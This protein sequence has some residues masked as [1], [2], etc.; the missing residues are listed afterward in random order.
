MAHARLSPSGSSRWMSCPGS[1]HLEALLPPD[2]RQSPYAARGTAIHELSEKALTISKPPSNWLGKQ[3][4]GFEVDQ[5]MV[6]IANVYVDWINEAKGLKFFEQRVSLVHVIPDCFGT[7]DCIILNQGRLI[8]ADLKTGAGVPVS[9][10]GNTQL[11]IYALGAFEKY[12]WLYGFEEITLVIIQP[13]I[14]HEPSVWT[15]TREELLEFAE[16]VKKAYRDIV[17]K[18]EHYVASD[19]ACR[20]CRAKTVC[21]ELNKVAKE[22]AQADFRAMREEMDAEQLADNLKRVPLLKAFIEA[23]E[24]SAKDRLLEGKSVPGFKVVE[25]RR[26][27]A[28][29]DESAVE[30]ALKEAGYGDVVYS[31]PKLLTVAQVEKVLKGT[32]FELD[33]FVETKPGSPT[34]ATEDDKRRALGPGSRAASDFAGLADICD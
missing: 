17:E 28:W 27:R 12:D 11:L 8:V 10:E 33:S 2:D 13:P 14:S 26:S 32:D 7:V 9:A 30:Q 25:G 24:A 4:Y 1:V 6:D 5:S 18:P 34:I 19:K 22:A 23:V 15:I 31:E 20:W 16:T 21:P 29:K 3:V